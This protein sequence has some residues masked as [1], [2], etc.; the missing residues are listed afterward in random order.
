MALLISSIA[1]L[2]PCISNKKATP[3]GLVAFS[4]N[5]LRDTLYMTRLREHIDRLHF[6]RFITTVFQHPQITRKRRRITGYIHDPLRLHV[7]H[8][9]QKL[10]VTAFTR[11]VDDD[12]VRAKALITPP[13]HELFC[14]PDEEFGVVHLVQTGVLL[15]VF[16]GFRNDFHSIHLLCLLGEE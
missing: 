7:E 6:L 15:R 1:L 4:F 11:R 9:F 16:H 2:I 13:R 10:L 3:R 5:E 12:D 8:R 14:F